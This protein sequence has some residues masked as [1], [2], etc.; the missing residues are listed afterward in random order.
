M[1]MTRRGFLASGAAGIVAASRVMPLSGQSD[2]ALRFLRVPNAV[3]IRVGGA[4]GALIQFPSKGCGGRTWCNGDG[5]GGGSIGQWVV[6]AEIRL[7]GNPIGGDCVVEVSSSGRRDTWA[8]GREDVRVF[9][10]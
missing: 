9:R 2:W 6:G 7:Y 5:S 3:E 1:T 4:R 10:R 8:F